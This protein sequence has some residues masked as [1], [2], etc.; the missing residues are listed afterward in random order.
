M[1][2]HFSVHG[3]FLTDH[4]RNLVEEGSIK[5]AWDTFATLTDNEDIF[6]DIVKGRKCFE[7]INEFEL[8]SCQKEDLTSKTLDY[9]GEI[10]GQ[11]SEDLEQANTFLNSPLKYY[12]DSEDMTIGELVNSNRD[13]L[14]NAQN[15]HRQAQ[16]NLQFFLKLF[17]LTQEDVILAHLMKYQSKDLKSSSGWITEKGWFLP[18]R[19]AGHDQFIY[20]FNDKMKTNFSIHD[21]EKDG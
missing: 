11:A 5:K 1:N 17:N 7:G 9:L 21:I 13:Y 10:A 14:E 18:V 12:E 19:E 6:R 15:A 3:D 16:E 8:I 2:L 20:A 4:I